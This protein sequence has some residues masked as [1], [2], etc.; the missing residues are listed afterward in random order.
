[1]NASWRLPLTASPSLLASITEKYDGSTM[2][3]LDSLIPDRTSSR[4]RRDKRWLPIDPAGWQRQR[5]EWAGWGKKPPR[6]V[7]L[8][9]RREIGGGGAH[10]T[11]RSA[12]RGLGSARYLATQAVQGLLIA[13]ISGGLFWLVW[14]DR[15]GLRDPRYLDGWV[16]AGGMG[17]Q[18]YFHIA[19]KT[20]SLSP[21]SA[22]RWRKIHFSRRPADRRLHR[23]FG[24]LSRRTPA[25][26]GRWRR[27]SCW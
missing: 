12:G 20:A 18:L 1:M 27:P 21:K 11:P 3:G 4:A 26:N 22:M 16:L 19:M 15:N 2:A 23:A 6:W 9:G 25:S 7:I 13:A 24:F 14:I 5:P 8:G 17:L 10:L